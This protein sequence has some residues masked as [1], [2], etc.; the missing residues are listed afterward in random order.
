METV[1]ITPEQND[2]DAEISVDVFK[3]ALA[4]ISGAW[5]PA[6]I[7]DMPEPAEEDLHQRYHIGSIGGKPYVE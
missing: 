6:L 7:K 3:Q 5:K 1:A 2:D 4:A